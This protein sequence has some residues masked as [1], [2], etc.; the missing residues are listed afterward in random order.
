MYVSI[1]VY[2]YIYTPTHTYFS[3]KPEFYT[4]F[5]QKLNYV[6]CQELLGNGNDTEAWPSTT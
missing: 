2:I 3:C 6:N 4:P 5:V 1:Y